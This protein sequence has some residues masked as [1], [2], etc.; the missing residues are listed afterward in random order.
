MADSTLV[1]VAM[2]RSSLVSMV[3]LIRLLIVP[4]AALASPPMPGNIAVVPETG[5]PGTIFAL[6]GVG[7][8]RSQAGGILNISVR[9]AQ[10]V[11]TRPT[12]AGS[13]EVVIGMNGDFQAWYDSAGLAAGQYTLFVWTQNGPDDVIAATILTITTA[14]SGQPSLPATGGGGQANAPRSLSSL[15]LGFIRE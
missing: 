11:P 14:P 8:P 6:I 15:G 9:P 10:A 4:D 3:I 12:V 1:S 2:L 13:V 7:Y 5:P